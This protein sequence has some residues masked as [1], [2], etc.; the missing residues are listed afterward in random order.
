M[1]ISQVEF[2][3]VRV[4]RDTGV[5]NEHVI[6]LIETDDGVRGWGEMSDLSHLPCTGS[7]STNFGP[8]SGNEDPSCWTTDGIRAAARFAS[9]SPARERGSM[10]S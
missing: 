10:S 9:R 2:Y 8:P 4:E 3:P 7:T 5:A 1:K 6:V